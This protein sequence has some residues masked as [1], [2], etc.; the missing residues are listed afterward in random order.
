M[1]F[2]ARRLIRRTG[3]HFDNRL[4]ILAGAVLIVLYLAG[5]PLGFLLWGSLKVGDPQSANPPTLENYRQ[6]YTD[7]GAYQL[8]LNSLLYALGS[9][10]FSLL[11]GTMLAW[12]IERTNTPFK[13]LFSAL[14][15]VPLII[16]GI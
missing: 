1:Q 15:M 16:P 4:F 2:S 14:A 5:V 7:P 6:A 12:T 11:L 13:S 9:S 3:I 10:V 8:L